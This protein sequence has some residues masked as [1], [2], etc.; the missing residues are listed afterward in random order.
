MLATVSR[1]DGAFGTQ[2]LYLARQT[3]QAVPVT[4]GLAGLAKTAGH[5]WPEVACKAIDLDPA[6]SRSD[7]DRRG[8]GNRR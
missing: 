5:V 7:R 1:L 6:F 3:T 4:G 8:G 2:G